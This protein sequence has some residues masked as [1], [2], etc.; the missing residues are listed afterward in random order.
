MSR[1]L[2]IFLIGPFIA[3]FALG[4]AS[5]VFAWASNRATPWWHRYLACVLLAV[6]VIHIGE[7]GR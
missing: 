1:A 7:G 5:A 4:I 2:M 3:Y 6:I